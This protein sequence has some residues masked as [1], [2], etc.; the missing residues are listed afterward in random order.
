MSESAFALDQRLAAD[1]QPIGDLPLCRLLLMQ[2]ANFPWLI[3]VPSRPGAIELIDLDETDRVV[4]M[5]E[6]AQ[7]SAA[8]KQITGCHKINVAALGNSVPQLHVHVIAR[9]QNDPAWPRPVW[10]QVPPRPYEP[11]ALAERIGRL[12]QAFDLP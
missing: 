5:R 7:V 6:I 10:G 11:V 9:F 2:D 12:R 4:L 1:T 8:L 3:L